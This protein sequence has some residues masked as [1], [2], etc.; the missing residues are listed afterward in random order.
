MFV[1]VPF[2][3]AEM[4]VDQFPLARR[5]VC[6]RR[7]DWGCFRREQGR[8]DKEDK[9]EESEEREERERAGQVEGVVLVVVVRAR[10]GWGGEVDRR[11]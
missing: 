5:V 1:S 3:A 4:A 7:H 9:E 6:Y 8:G 2:L 11:W 10:R